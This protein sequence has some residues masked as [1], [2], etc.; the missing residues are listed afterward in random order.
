MTYEKD[1]IGKGR[2]NEKIN[3]IVKFSF[4]LEDLQRIAHEYEGEKW[5][6]IE[7]SPMKSPDKFGRTHVAWV[8]ERVEN[9]KPEPKSTAKTSKQT[10]TKA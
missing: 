4:K 5:V 7:T 10:K 6:T 1:Y 8:T 2:T 9:N 3:N